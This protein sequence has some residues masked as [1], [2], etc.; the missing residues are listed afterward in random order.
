MAKLK[1]LSS[2]S[3]GNCY[4]LFKDNEILILDAGIRFKEIQ[5]GIDYRIADVVGVLVTH[6]HLDHSLAAEDF[7]KCGIPVFEPY[8]GGRQYAKLGSFK[9]HAF[10]VPHDGT[11][12]RGFLIEC[13]E[14]IGNMLYMTDLEYSAYTFRSYKV[15]HMLVEANYQKEYVSEEVSKRNH[16]LQG[17]CELNTTL[18]IIEA[19]KTD[20][21]R[22]VILC[23]LSAESADPK[24]VTEQAQ[25]I[26]GR[27]VLVD[28]AAAGKEWELTDRDKCPFM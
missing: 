22:N 28:Y 2:G 3:Q 26:A 1:C 13:G 12:N 19:N 17:H 8:K 4:L 14:G 10:D 9:V 24:E 23:H 7:M 16:V 15:S 25:K 6:V 21:L 18:G 27:G 11:P 5:R 20:A